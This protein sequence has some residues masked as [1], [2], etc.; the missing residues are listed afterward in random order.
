MPI[1]FSTLVN[2]SGFS[3]SL[4]LCLPFYEF[5]R[6]SFWYLLQHFPRNWL[7]FSCFLFFTISSKC[8]SSL[9]FHSQIAYTRFL[10]GKFLNISQF[11][12]YL[13]E[14]NSSLSPIPPLSSV[15]SVFLVFLLPLWSHLNGLAFFTNPLNTTINGV[16][17]LSFFLSI[18]HIPCFLLLSHV[19]WAFLI[20][21]LHSKC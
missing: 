20:D 13:N 14:Y 12:L 21:E 16:A 18:L 7:F 3:V 17:S 2:R 10:V 19:Y 1:Q 6:Q 9:Q 11:F 5:M 8:Q 15:I 4:L